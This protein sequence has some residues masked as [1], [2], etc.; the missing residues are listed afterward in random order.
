MNFSILK[1]LQ[2][3]NDSKIVLL[4]MDG[5]GGLPLGPGG[6]TELETAKTPNLDRLAAEGVCGL[7]QP[8][9]SGVTPGSGP[10]HLG[11]FGY[12]PIEHQVGRGVLEAIGINFPLS[13]GDVAARGN[14][15]TIDAKGL[16]TDRRAG[17]IATEIN[18]GICK[19]LKT[20]KVPGVEVFV[21]P[22]KE[23]RLLVVLRG[24]GLSGAIDDTDPQAEGKAPLD[25]IATDPAA[26]KTAAYFKE[27]LAKAK[28]VLADSHPA[29]MM[30]LRGF[31]SRPSWPTYREVFGVRSAAIASYPMYRGV[32]SLVGMDVL[33]T[34]SEI[35]D[36]FTTLE[37]RWSDYDFFFF[38]VKKTDSYGENGD[39]DAK[40][41]VIEDVDRQ[42]G[43]LL[44]L[45]PDVL[46]VTGDHSTPAAMKSHSWHPVPVFIHG[47]N[48]RSDLVTSFGERACLS[49]GLGNRI[50]ATELMPI[51]M[52]HAGR[53]EK[54]GA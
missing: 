37:E 40:V 17:R 51:A 7:H 21:E 5:L 33:E 31:A 13:D 23:H 44:A 9:G 43:R 14:F 32:A 19:K 52:A 25:P 20:I 3:E 2:V 22:V 48:V 12:D 39:F 28:E 30:T 18:V 15:C 4:I 34:G 29:N 27:F 35:P 10:A 26:E 41:H 24:K 45:K 53:I 49:G 1:K 36:E 8:I 54:F 38:H 11:V 47:R 50:P 6:K 42:L 46:I 16:I